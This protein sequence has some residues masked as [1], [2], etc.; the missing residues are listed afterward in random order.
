M[1]FSIEFCDLALVDGTERM[2]SSREARDRILPR[3]G[4]DVSYP[5]EF[6]GEEAVGP[7]GKRRGRRRV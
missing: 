2:V 6:D 7:D 3:V 5:V 4:R 1:I